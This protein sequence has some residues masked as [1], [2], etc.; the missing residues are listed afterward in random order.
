MKIAQ[1]DGIPQTLLKPKYERFQSQSMLAA[2]RGTI[3][4]TSVDMSALTKPN[5]MD[6]VAKSDYIQLRQ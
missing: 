6:G 5:G 1:F 4:N 3:P 2:I